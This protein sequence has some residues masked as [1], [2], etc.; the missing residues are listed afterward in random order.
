MFDPLRRA[1]THDL[2]LKIYAIFITL[3]LYLNANVNL[4][5][6]KAAKQIRRISVKAGYVNLPDNLQVT[7]PAGI[8]EIEVSGPS[9]LLSRGEDIVRAHLD[10]SRAEEGAFIGDVA[11]EKRQDAVEIISFAP[12]RLH[13][14]IEEVVEKTFRLQLYIPLQG[15]GKNWFMD[16]EEVRITGTRSKMDSVY[17]V[18]VNA[19]MLLP[20]EKM[21]LKPQAISLDRKAISGLK[22]EPETVWIEMAAP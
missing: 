11:V 7:S 19:P 3:I 8:V 6:D 2:S 22:A 1:L 13:V 21:E 17:Q 9:E 10:L 14:E 20:G 12:R 16:T 15:A 4:S 5:S 18:I